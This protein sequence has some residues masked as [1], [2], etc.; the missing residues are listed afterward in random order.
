[1][2]KSLKRWLFPRHPILDREYE[3]KRAKYPKLPFD[4]KLLNVIILNKHFDWFDDVDSK[5]TIIRTSD[6]VTDLYFDYP[7]LPLPT[8]IYGI[9][10][11]I[12]L[13]WRTGKG[14][15]LVT[16]YDMEEKFNNILVSIVDGGNTFIKF[17]DNHYFNIKDAVGLIYEK[18]YGRVG[19]DT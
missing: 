9:D 5:G 12:Y 19:R 2:I 1:M 4:A 13:A 6:I 16:I 10:D 14:Q 11:A 8:S 18:D 7:E 15:V 3:A 17:T